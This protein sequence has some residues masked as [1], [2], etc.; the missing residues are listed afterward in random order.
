MSGHSWSENDRCEF[1]GD[2]D[3]MADK[4]CGENPAVEAEYKQWIKEQNSTDSATCDT[5]ALTG[6]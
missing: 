2:K 1:C 4:F 3:W 5:S 6:E